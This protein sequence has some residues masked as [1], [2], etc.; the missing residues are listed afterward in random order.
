MRSVFNFV[1]QVKAVFGL[2]GGNIRLSVDPEGKV[3]RL[4]TL[5]QFELICIRFGT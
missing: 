5:R 1:L 3:G 2:Y 4:C